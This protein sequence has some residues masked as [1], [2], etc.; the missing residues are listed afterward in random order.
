[1]KKNILLFVLCPLF[2]FGQNK[3]K[4]ILNTITF[5]S[6]SHE[7][8]RKQMWSKVIEQ[9]PD[10]WI[11]GGDIIYGDTQDMNVL[12]NKYNQQKKH[13]DYQKL[14][15]TCQIIGVWDDHDY[16]INDGGKHYAKKVQS[17]AELIR[18]L[19]IS[20]RNR[21]HKHE[22][23]YNSYI[24]GEKGKLVKVILLDTRYFRDTIR[25]VKI[26]GE[27]RYE[28][29]KNG[30][31]LGEKQ[32]KWLEKELKNSKAD[33]NIIMSSIQLL[34]AEHPYEKWANF[35]KAR[36]RFL[37]LLSKVKPKRPLVLSGDRHISEFSKIKVEGFEY[38]LYDFT[39]SGLTHTW[40]NTMS[41]KEDNQYRE[42]KLIIAKSFGVIKV[43]WKKYSLTLQA[44][45]ENNELQLEKE[46]TF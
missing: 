4:K 26:N 8:D 24:F 37:D 43:N 1:M 32:W 6:C 20:E 7:Y 23:A 14:L 18:F 45:G 16:G 21:I 41:A 19:D 44:I 13:K 46:L 11:W 3:S 36:Q 5:G 2:V 27:R 39:S 30:D 31:I 33:F 42:G 34:S 22:G 17:K 25:K 38:P 15:K 35:P 10:L 28:S 29:N 40:S 12:R 9:K